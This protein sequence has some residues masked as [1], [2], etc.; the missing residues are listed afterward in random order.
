M[1]DQ[2]KIE[3]YARLSIEKGVGLKKGQKLLIRADVDAAPFARILAKV[4]WEVGAVD[5]IIRY[6]DEQEQRLRFLH[7]E[8]DIFGVRKVYLD[9]FFKYAV[10]EDYQL[11][12]VL[13]ADPEN[14]KGIEPGRIAKETRMLSESSKPLSDKTTSGEIQWSLTAIPSASWAKKV[15]PNEASEEDAIAKMWD[16]IFLATRVSEGDPV[17]NWDEHV[18]N[19]ALNAKKLQNY[20]FDSLV[21]KNSY[22]TNL[23]IGLPEG[24]FWA[25][26]GEKAETGNVFIANIPTEEVFTAPH[27][28]RADGI[29]YATKPLVYLGNIIDKFWIK[30]EKGKVVDYKAEIG[31]DIL[32]QMLTVNENADRLGEV[33][34]VPHSSPISTSGILWYNTLYDEN[35]SCHIALGRGYSFT[36][37]KT[38]GLDEASCEKEGLNQSLSHNDFMIGSACLSILGKTKDGKEIEI[39]KD[40]EWSI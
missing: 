30:F 1:V 3:N 23:E 38:Q 34:L 5:V 4:A 32:E 14:L 16:A 15:F 36:L 29:V 31:H 7:G 9:E 24:H 13:S 25:S 37:P 21:F 28:E 33:A 17:K 10:E 20:E 39:F 12:A 11:V 2:T 8:E 6:L 35:A 40:G 26:C 22:G 19:L 27:R 18:K